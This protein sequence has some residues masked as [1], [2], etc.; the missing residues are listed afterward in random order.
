MSLSSFIARQSARPQGLFGRIFFFF[1]FDRAN[2]AANSL[3]HDLLPYDAESRLLEVGFGGGDLLLRIAQNLKTGRIDG[4]ELSREM[5]SRARRRARRMRLDHRIGLHWGSVD[6]LPFSDST[7][8]CACSVHTIYFWP[9]LNRGIA[10]LARVVKPGGALVLGFSSIDAL[11]SDGW[12][13]QGFRAYSADQIGQACGANGFEHELL[14]ESER[15]SQ[16]RH[17]ALRVVKSA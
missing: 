4:L 17:F 8:D 10:E 15:R 16:G 2:A 1:F 12:V 5:I 11:E 6:A 9:D 14:G 3:V 13:E 7:F